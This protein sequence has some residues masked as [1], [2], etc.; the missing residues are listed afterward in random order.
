MS[1][2]TKLV[3]QLRRKPWFMT[4][5]KGERIYTDGEN[6]VVIKHDLDMRTKHKIVL[7][8]QLLALRELSR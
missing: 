4:G 8:R 7:I 3:H 2:Y 6:R 1:T 5:P